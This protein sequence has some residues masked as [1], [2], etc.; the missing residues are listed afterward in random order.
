MLEDNRV[1][2]R[3]VDEGEHGDEASD[4]S[5]EEELVAPDVNHPLS[6]VLLGLGLHAEEGA[7]QVDHFPGEEEGEPGQTGKSGGAGAE[8]DF[9]AFVVLV[10]A[11][12]NVGGAVAEAVEDEDEG[13]EAEG[14]H[15]EA[16]DDHVDEEFGGEDTLFELG[17]LAFVRETTKWKCFGGLH[18]EEV[19]A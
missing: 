13:G 4:N 8:D 2:D 6:E 17:L 10:A 16:I 7:A 3:D 5:P 9:A 1:D 19:A 12:A 15:P 14:G 11:V 18:S